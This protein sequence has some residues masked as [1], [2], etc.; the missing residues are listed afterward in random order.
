MK[1]INN[2]E[3]KTGDI[4]KIENAYFKNDNG[5]YFISHSPGDPSWCGKD[6][7]LHKIGKRGK[8]STAKNNIAFWPLAAFCSDRSKNAAAYEHNAKYATIEII[9]SIDNSEVIK[10]FEEEV[11]NH[12]E[13][14]KN[15][16]YRFGEANETTIKAKVIAEHYRKVVKRMTEIIEVKT[17]PETIETAPE[18][19]AT[20]A[21][22][23]ATETAPETTGTPKYYAINETLA[24][25]AWYA[26]HMGNY[27]KNSTTD[28]YKSS[29]NEAYELAAKKKAKVSQFYHD[30]IDNLVDRYSYKLANWYNDYNRNQA[31]CPSW[32]ITG[33]ANYPVRKH[34][35][36]MSREASLWSEYDAIKAILEKI[37]S[38]GTGPID[39]ADP[40][41]KEMLEERLNNYKKTL[42]LYKKLNAYWR[43]HKTFIGCTDLTPEKAEEYTEKTNDTLSRCAWISQPFP[44]YE[45]TSLRDKI[46][47]TT[48]RLEEL[49]RRQEAQENGSNN[50]ETF[51]GGEIVRNIELDRL[52]IIFND[53]PDATIR[54]ELKRNGFRWSPKNKAWQRQL[55][56]NAERALKSLNL[57]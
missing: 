55:T 24:E 7:S 6:Y 16:Y 10:H 52:Q 22:P 51:E 49:N 53:I 42:E 1:D 11:A 27:K 46:K 48:E 35:K 13:Q 17:A 8:I 19:I 25:R 36:K 38:I 28:E 39:L 4:V 3:M 57:A 9:N 30:K 14:A 15:Y 40:H 23:E 5:Y 37:R 44:A 33:P 12:E 21:A 31:S 56:P 41:A 50:N 34:E 18:A 32:F 26:V 43:K 20:E 29:V 45:L 54:T 2:I 47:R